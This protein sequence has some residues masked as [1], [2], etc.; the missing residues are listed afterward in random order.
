M[1]SYCSYS[2]I[3]QCNKFNFNVYEMTATAFNVFSIKIIFKYIYHTEIYLYIFS[4]QKII[5]IY[6]VYK[7]IINIY[8]V[9]K[10]LFIYI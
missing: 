5:Y 10:K 1:D 9:Y 7:K 3:N 6:L 8:L 4:I 2:V